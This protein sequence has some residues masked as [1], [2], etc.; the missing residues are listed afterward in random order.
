ME[1]RDRA[2]KLEFR[3]TLAESWRLEE[4]SLL[5]DLL[6]VGYY[7]IQSLVFGGEAV[8]AAL[9]TLVISDHDVPTGSPL[10]L[11]GQ[12]DRLFFF[13]VCHVSTMRSA[14]SDFQLGLLGTQFFFGGGGRSLMAANEGI[15]WPSISRRISSSHCSARSARCLACARSASMRLN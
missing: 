11:E 14:E 8:D 12:H 7:P 9:M 10:V 2:G 15:S 4:G 3:N 5:I 13:S 6:G 1:Q